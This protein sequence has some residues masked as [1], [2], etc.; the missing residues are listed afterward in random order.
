MILTL[1][2]VRTWD[3]YGGTFLGLPRTNYYNSINGSGC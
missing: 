1:K 3:S 2:I